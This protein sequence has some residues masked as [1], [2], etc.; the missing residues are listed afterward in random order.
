MNIQQF[1]L[2]F[3]ARKRPA[4]AVFAVTVLT[5]LVVSLIL[6]KTYQAV[7]SV[8]IDLKSPDPIAGVILPGMMST[9]Y[10]ATQVDIVNSDRVAQRAVGLLKLEESP[11]IRDQWQQETQGR[12]SL[13]VW[14]GQLLQNNLN[15]KPSR[16]SSVVNIAYSAADPVYAAA[17]ANA[18]AQAYI[19]TTIELRVNP[20]KQYA[21]WFETQIK[22]QRDRLDIAQKALADYQ[23]QSGIVISDGRLDYELQKFNELSSQ[24]TLAQ[25]QGTDSTSKQLQP[26]ADTLPEVMQNP[27]INQLKAELV[28]MESSLKDLSGNLGVNHPAY[29]RALSE[30]QSLKNR[31]NDEIT[32]VSSAIGTAGLVSQAKVAELTNAIEEQK[33]KVF[34][35]RRQRDTINLLMRDVDTA[36]RAYDG[37]SQRYNQI[38]LEAQTAQT[39]VAVLTPATA[40]LKHSKPKVFINMLVAIFLGGLLALALVLVQ[41]A[42][43]PKVRSQEALSQALPV[44]CLG[45]VN[46]QNKKLFLKTAPLKAAA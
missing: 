7:N 2:I 35:L 46:T 25:A 1:L 9:G 15:V 36:Q 44:P 39:N 23:E 18:F 20:A 16:E 28:R 42:L 24:L 26:Q 37:I 10:M 19:D 22:A 14:M 32:H 40:P 43:D 5:A 41:E 3:L 45:Q 13:P 21:S 31:I 8:V 30:Q 34:D 38:A 12:V 29:K 6:P 4:I 11:T 17:V 27:L 33:K